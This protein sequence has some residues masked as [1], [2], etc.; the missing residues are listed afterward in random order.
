MILTTPIDRLIDVYR[1]RGALELLRRL[2]HQ[3]PY[4]INERLLGSRFWF[5]LL[6]LINSYRYETVS[7]PY[8]IEYVDPADVR[9]QSLRRVK[10]N[11]SRWRN[12]GKVIG[13]NWDIESQSPKYD[14]GNDLLYQAIDKRFRHGESWEDTE[15]VNYTLKSLREGN[16]EKTWRAVVRNED[17]L[18]E[19][20]EQLDKLYERIQ[21]DGYRSKA[22]IF[23]SEWTDPMGYYPRTFKYSI[24][25]VMV[26]FGR[27]GEPLLVDGRHRL[28]IA[29]VCD[30]DEIPVLPV[31]RH[32]DF[33]NGEK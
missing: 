20:C 16:N 11:R 30:V 26:D 2:G 4:Q 27:E 33:V 29:K 18:W 32:T 17:D 3:I 24:D 31:V 8:A 28:F 7:E 19:R 22:D 12:V 21:N 14:L 9:Y 25:E 5:R 23:A 15:Y 13:G 10:S 1:D 6:H